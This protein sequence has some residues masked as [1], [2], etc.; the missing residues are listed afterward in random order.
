MNESFA[1]QGLRRKTAFNVKLECEMAA[2][3][4]SADRSR[5]GLDVLGLNG[6]FNLSNGNVKSR[7]TRLIEPDSHRIRTPARL[8]KAY[9]VHSGDR[10]GNLFLDIVGKLH[11]VH[12]AFTSVGHEHVHYHS[13]FGTLFDR[14]AALLYFR[15]QLR[16]GTSDGILNI[17][18]RSIR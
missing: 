5:G 13:V 4:F 17:Y 12:A 3:V 8:H 2:G 10:I 14:D 1:I 11:N 18:K 15:R 9:A 7:K 16:F 6:R